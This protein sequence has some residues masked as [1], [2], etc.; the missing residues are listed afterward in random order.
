MNAGY[1]KLRKR[2]LVAILALLVFVVL[3]GYVL[4][5]G[6]LV[7]VLRE[8]GSFCV[9]ELSPEDDKPH[10]REITHVPVARWW[11]IDPFTDHYAKVAEISWRPKSKS[12]LSALDRFPKLY[13]LKLSGN[14][15]DDEAFK[16]LAKVPTLWDLE[17]HDAQRVTAEGI[18]ALG[19]LRRLERLV[20]QSADI[21][22]EVFEAMPDLPNLRHLR[23]DGTNVGDAGLAF[24][25]RSPILEIVSLR[26]TR[27]GSG[28]LKY[29]AN[30]VCLCVL[31]V[32]D[33]SVDNRGIDILN[34]C[35][36]LRTLEVENSKITPEAYDR[37][38][39]RWQSREED[40]LKRPSLPFPPWLPQPAEAQETVDIRTTVGP[41]NLSDPIAPKDE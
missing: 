38:V 16:H 28:G 26:G 7:Q 3:W 29:L 35:P 33:T 27:V 9:S 36:S 5:R 11:H 19:A 32:S 1:A 24:L 31:D 2:V 30:H 15:V 12:E 25:A 17:I 23:L 41:L 34:T 4:P 10:W 20:L 21:D 40:R 22:T 14:S 6:P 37:L 8:G 13:R 18:K 39:A